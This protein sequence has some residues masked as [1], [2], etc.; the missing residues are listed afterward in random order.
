MTAEE[1]WKSVL[2]YKTYLT[3]TSI[4]SSRTR[5]FKICVFWFKLPL[6]VFEC[7]HIFKSAVF[8][9]K[10]RF[11]WCS[12]KLA[13]I[14]LFKATMHLQNGHAQFWKDGLFLNICHITTQV[15]SPWLTVQFARLPGNVCLVVSPLEGVSSSP[16]WSP[17]WQEGQGRGG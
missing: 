12:L 17:Q 6:K 2:A 7:T 9:A 5:L 3:T 13:S 15:C 14:W 8:Q 16:P 11:L 1:K 10:C 4:Y